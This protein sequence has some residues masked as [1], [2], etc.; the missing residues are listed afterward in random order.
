[1]KAQTIGPLDVIRL[2][3]LVAK[4]TIAQ[5]SPRCLSDEPAYL[6]DRKVANLSPQTTSKFWRKD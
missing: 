4:R 6:A 1:M 3:P 2:T 5:K